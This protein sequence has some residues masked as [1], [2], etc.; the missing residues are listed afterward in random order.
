[1]RRARSC[2]AVLVGWAALGLL[3]LTASLSPAGEGQSA[4]AALE[5]GKAPRDEELWQ[6]VAEGM[7]RAER[8]IRAKDA[9]DSTQRLQQQ[10][11]KDLT[12]LLQS[13]EQQ[14]AAGGASAQREPAAASRAGK[15]DGPGAGKQGASPGPGPP[16]GAPG[17]PIP[18]ELVPKGLVEVWGQLPEQVQRL[19]Q[20]PLREQFLPGYEQLISD[21]YRRLAEGK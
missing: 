2:S 16:P 21:Y 10:I 11:V 12:A 19:I 6:R 18:S 7:R 8:L 13:A 20:S 1:M 9:S 4:A 15:S 3:S 17:P 5:A 14:K